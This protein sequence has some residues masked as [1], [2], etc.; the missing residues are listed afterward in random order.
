MELRG[1]RLRLGPP[2][3]DYDFD[4]DSNRNLD[5]T[6]NRQNHCGFGAGHEHYDGERNASKAVRIPVKTQRG[7]DRSDDRSIVESHGGRLW[8]DNNSSR[9]ASF[10]F[11][12]PT[13]AEAPE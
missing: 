11:T 12:L 5:E 6:M 2:G 7:A 9:G 8:A 4:W 10:Y 3:G 1:R 13:K